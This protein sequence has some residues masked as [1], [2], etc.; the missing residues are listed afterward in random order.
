MRWFVLTLLVG[1]TDAEY[2]QYE[3]LGC[4]G[5]I[6]CYSGGKVIYDG[7]ST[8]KIATE[9][10]SDGWFLKDAKTGDLVRVSG[11]CVI[12]NPVHCGP[13]DLQDAK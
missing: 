11:S 8:G 9:H 12:T 7:T 10:G 13:G 3:A 5:H 2:A 4:P 6:L 1:C